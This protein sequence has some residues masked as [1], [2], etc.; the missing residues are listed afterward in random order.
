M[1]YVVKLDYYFVMSGIA[2]II[3]WV[4]KNSPFW[5]FI[6]NQISQTDSTQDLKQEVDMNRLFQL[7][8]DIFY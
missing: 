7:G 2:G 4:K 3:I 5:F 1:Y 6:W 8:R